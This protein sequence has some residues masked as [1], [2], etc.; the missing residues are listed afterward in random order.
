MPSYASIPRKTP[1]K[2]GTKRRK[3]LAVVILVC[4]VAAGAAWFFTKDS[5]DKNMSPAANQPT[6]QTQTKRTENN[7]SP[8]PAP[9]FDK[10]QF[11]IADPA[12]IWVVAN[13]QR[14]LNP[15]GYVPADL[16]TPDV[17]LKYQSGAMETQLRQETGQ[18]LLDMFAASKTDGIHLMLV[19]GYR[20]YSYQNNLFNHYVNTQG[21]AT[22]LTQS[23]R[24]GHSEHQ[25]GLA[26][27]V[28][29]LD[30]ECEIEACFGDTPEG[31]WV[32]ANA[33]RFG[34]IVRYPNGLT[35]TTGYDYEPWHLRYVGKPLAAEMKRTNTKTLEEFFGL[36]AAPEY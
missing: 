13:K 16:T 8:P 9:S 27:D 6:E 3:L 4:A 19:S 30:R 22:A 23:A 31:K 2:S 35:S 29:A 14:Q 18:A 34:F 12:S 21:L 26:A 1:K 15:V 32:A 28:G 17:P 7:D 11:S 10:K 24:P 25:T 5:A 36:P 33:Y 20:S